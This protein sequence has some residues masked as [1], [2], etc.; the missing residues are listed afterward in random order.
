M[1]FEIL[2]LETFCVFNG[3]TSNW[4]TGVS[5]GEFGKV[6]FNVPMCPNITLI[7]VMLGV[8]AVCCVVLVLHLR[9]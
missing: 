2:N 8:G 1:F 7:L 6:C 9:P 5:V 4:R 3:I